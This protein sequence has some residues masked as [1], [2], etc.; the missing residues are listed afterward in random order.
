MFWTTTNVIEH[1]IHH[2]GNDSF[3]F[4]IIYTRSLHRECLPW[5]CLSICKYSPIESFQHTINHWSSCII[6]Y[7]HLS[8][9]HFKYSI[10]CE[11]LILFIWVYTF[12]WLSI[13]EFKTIK[14]FSILFWTIQWS[15][16]THHSHIPSILLLLILLILLHYRSILLLLLY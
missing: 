13:T 1:T 2:S 3:H 16:S 10:Q 5:W 14:V 7:V 6:E 4:S 15:H 8:S 12:Y 11:S 9:L